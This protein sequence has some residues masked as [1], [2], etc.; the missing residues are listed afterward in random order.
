MPVYKSSPERT[1][2]IFGSGIVLS[3]HQCR[4]ERSGP[5]AESVVSKVLSGSD[6]DRTLLTPPQEDQL[7]EIMR[8]QATQECPKWVFDE[9]EHIIDE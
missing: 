2:R 9:L 7:R 4:T 5:P 8:E 3:S 6:D 1:R